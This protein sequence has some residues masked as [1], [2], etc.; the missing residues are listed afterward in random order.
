MSQTIWHH[1]ENLLRV[2]LF[3]INFLDIAATEIIK[4]YHAL[5]IGQKAERYLMM[6][7]DEE[8]QKNAGKDP[9]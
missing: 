4:H 6:R 3:G 8:L 1:F 9:K 2:K 7:F 5:E